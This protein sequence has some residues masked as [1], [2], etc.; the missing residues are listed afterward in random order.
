MEVKLAPS[1]NS[2]ANSLGL[3]ESFAA[4]RVREGG[5]A[6]WVPPFQQGPRWAEEKQVDD[7]VTGLI[8]DDGDANSFCC[9]HV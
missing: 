4:L 2:H 8:G 5:R 9:C 6:A 3:I 7:E 1:S